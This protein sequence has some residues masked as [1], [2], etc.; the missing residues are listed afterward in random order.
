MKICSSSS[1]AEV[2]C[3]ILL[4]NATMF[5]PIRQTHPLSSPVILTTSLNYNNGDDDYLI[6]G[7]NLITLLAPIHICPSNATQV[8]RFFRF[9]E[10]F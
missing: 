7:R 4:E 9:L 8:L 10:E 6:G 3:W 1:S 2:H 5:G